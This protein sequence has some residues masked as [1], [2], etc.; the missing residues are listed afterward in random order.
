M[1]VSSL[2]AM[3]QLGELDADGLLTGTLFSYDAFVRSLGAMWSSNWLLP[4]C[5][6]LRGADSVQPND[7][8]LRRNGIGLSPQETDVLLKVVE[9]CTNKVMAGQLGTTEATAK[10]NVE[11]VLRKIGAENRTQATVWAIA[12][13]AELA[14]LNK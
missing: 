14:A 3:A 6:A 1:L 12:N 5:L 13:M 10:A 4:M 7:Q 2:A 11:S 8:P 9:G